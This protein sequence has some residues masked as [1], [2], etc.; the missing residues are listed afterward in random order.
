MKKLLVSLTL[1]ASLVTAADS[2]SAF[3]V[4]DATHIESSKVVIKVNPKEILELFERE[5]G[6]Y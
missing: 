1:F 5:P 3:Q 6:S 4:S 2:A